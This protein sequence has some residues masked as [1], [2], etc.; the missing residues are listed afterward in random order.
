M[1]TPDLAA[2]RGEGCTSWAQNGKGTGE[3]FLLALE[4]SCLRLS[5]LAYSPCRRLSKEAP[6]VSK[7][8]QL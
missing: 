5:F 3:V 2:G 4:L 7:E 1:H 6:T 8:A